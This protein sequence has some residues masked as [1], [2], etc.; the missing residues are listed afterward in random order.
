MAKLSYKARQNLSPKQFAIPPRGNQPGKYPID[1]VGR[2]RN[3]LARVS[4]FGSVPEK[5]IVRAKVAKR[6]PNIDAKKRKALAKKR[7]AQKS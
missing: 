6:Y 3:A 7:L 5:A 1:T 4:Q 2:A